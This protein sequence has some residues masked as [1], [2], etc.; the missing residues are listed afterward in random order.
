MLIFII[1]TYTHLEG[2]TEGNLKVVLI[3]FA[4]SGQQNHAYTHL[5]QQPAQLWRRANT[6]NASFVIS[7]WRKFDL[8]QS[9]FKGLQIIRGKKSQILQDLQRQIHG[10]NS[11][12]CGN[13]EGIF[14]A[15]FAKKQTRKQRKVYFSFV[16]FFS[17]I[18]KVCKL[19]HAAS[20][21]EAPKL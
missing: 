6:R 3:A 10:E 18:C 11:Q 5:I 15:N 17:I 14:G 7:S 1:N 13:F 16:K 12:F 8:T 21:R 9:R 4:C 20:N 19:Q 2:G